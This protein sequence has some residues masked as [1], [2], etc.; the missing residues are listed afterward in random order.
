MLGEQIGDL[1]GRRTGRRTISVESGFRVEVSFED[2][3]KLMGIEGGN[4]GTYTSTA[5]ADGS[6]CGEG[7]GV[8]ITPDGET[9]T[10]K[11]IGTG[12]FT[13]NGGVS[14]R[15]ALT[16][17]TTSRKLAQLNTFAGVFEYEIDPDGNSHTRIWAW[18]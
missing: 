1:R 6:L 2:K 10:W 13:G 18:K 12:R 11:G 17:N 16:Y 15:G 9:A 3:G 8:F 5:R 14:Y 4:I 7:Q